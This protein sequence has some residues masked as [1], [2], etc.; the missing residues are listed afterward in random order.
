MKHLCPEVT[1]GRGADGIKSITV[2]EIQEAMR[3]FVMSS[4]T[5]LGH[6]RNN[7]YN[8]TYLAL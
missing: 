1:Q 2:A 4:N 5:S 3:R 8:S 6:F 7:N